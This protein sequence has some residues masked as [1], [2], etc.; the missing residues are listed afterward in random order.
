[1]TATCTARPATGG[2]GDGTVFQ[3]NSAL[4]VAEEQ[5]TVSLAVGGDGKAQYGVETGKVIFRRTGDTTDALTVFYKVK[6]TAQAGVDFKPLSG[7]ITIPAGATQ[8]KIK[9]KPLNNP[10]NHGKLKAKVVVVPPTDGSYLLDD[11]HLAK[12]V[13]VGP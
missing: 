7:A 12:I 8:A 1:M 5:Q 4:A 11:A 3:L 10:E 9:I 6:G 13:V 2:N